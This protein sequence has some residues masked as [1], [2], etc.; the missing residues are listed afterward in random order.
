MPSVAEPIEKGR[1]MSNRQGSKSNE[2]P[3]D[4]D[5]NAGPSQTVKSAW[6]LFLFI[7]L[8]WLFAA[9]GGN[10]PRS[11]TLGY[12]H[13][14]IVIRPFIL[15][16]GMDLSYRF[17]F[18][19][20]MPADRGFSIVADVQQDGEAQ[21][22]RV[23]LPEGSSGGSLREQRMY[24]AI[25]ALG[26]RATSEVADQAAP[27]LAE[28]FGLAILKKFNASNV[29]LT[30]RARDPLNFEGV[31]QGRKIDDPQ[32]L[33]NVYQA[34]LKRLPK[35]RVLF[36][37]KEA[38]PRDVVPSAT[39]APGTSATPAPANKAAATKKAE[40]AANPLD[41][42]LTPAGPSGAGS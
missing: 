18:T 35:D 30:V 32:V 40:D 9:V 31:R 10:E 17:T 22:L 3:V 11:N 24:N 19:D 34:S 7:H 8:F 37:K 28:P 36:L 21:P 5:P 15:A 41:K 16:L 6:T 26:L 20:W 39:P 1:A 42:F 4:I 25:R 27:V 33:Q 14:A 2:Q 29:D 13:D 23:V 38:N 12:L